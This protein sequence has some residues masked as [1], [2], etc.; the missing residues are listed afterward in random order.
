MFFFYRKPWGKSSTFRGGSDH[1]TQ[2]I[3]LQN[4]ILNTWSVFAQKSTDLQHLPCA[5]DAT[6]PSLAKGDHP[7][8]PQHA[9]RAAI[10]QWKP[11]AQFPPKL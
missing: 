5:M 8:R 6:T 9:A 3:R 7:L 4:R 1:H 11:K 10:E 2:V